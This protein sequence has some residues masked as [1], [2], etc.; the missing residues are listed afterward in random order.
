MKLMVL[1]GNSLV[2]RAFFGIK[3]LTTKDGRYTNAIY[4]FQNILLNLL[5]AHQPDAVAIA[6]DERAPTFRHNA[7]DGYKATRHGM[8]EELAQQMP[9]L[10]E[11]LTD[12]G[13]VQVSKAGWEADD[14]LGTLA[15]ACEAAGGTTL[16]ATGDRDSLQLVDDATTVLLATNK[17][18]IPMDPAAI[19]EKYGIE[20]PQLIDV[21]SLMGDSSDNIPGVPGIGE[22]TALALI[23]KFGSLQG[24]YDNIEDK[25]VKPGQRAKLTANRGKAD[26]SYMLGTIRRDAPIETD[27]SAYIRR[28]GDPAAAA[29]LLAALEMHKLVDRWG[30]E[31]GAA[32]AAAADAAP[33]QAVE[34]SPLPLLLE[35]RF[36]AAQ[37][38]TKTG[39]GSWYLVQGSEVYLPD[40]DRLAALLDGDAEI[41]AFDAKPLYR[42]ALAHG[43]V[44]K[45]LRFDGKLAA[46]LLNPSASGYEVKSLAAEYGVHAAFHCEDAP[47]AGVLAGLCDTLAAALDESGQRKLL[48]EMELPLARVLADMGQPA[49]RGKQV[50]TWLHRGVRSFDEMSN[51]SKPLRQQLA[52]AYTISVPTVARKQE[53]RLD[54]T[55]KYLW[56]LPDGNCIETVL[57]QYHHGSTVCISSQVGCRMGCAFCASTVAGKVRDLTAGEMLDQVLFTQLDSG[58]EISNIVLMG[59]GEPLD[60]RDNVLRFLRLVN[61]PDGLNIGMRHISLSTCGVVP[62]IDTL[63]EED[64]QLTLSVSLHA[65]DSET[66]SRIMPVNRAWDVEELFAACHRY[67]RRTGRRISF[68]YAMIDGVNDHDWQAD[69]IARRIAGMPGHVNLIPLNDVVESPFKPSRRIAAFQ[70]RLE[71]HGITATV[72]R[73][74]GGDIDASCGQLRRRAMEERKGEDPE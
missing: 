54:G 9:V 26:L 69:L 38:V 2:N 10:K 12:L 73:S 30:L 3:L 43:G 1:D 15:A 36:Y 47:D 40:T 20:P 53:S 44:G 17:E 32:P 60:N 45:A 65:P 63:A 23:S 48:D 72:R 8:P 37:N 7:Y 58:R 74:L 13:F 31:S 59:I 68:E 71:S 56:E 33:V 16:L 64:L 67:F 19:R 18:T 24:V 5:A 46:Y 70:K 66:R 52:Q 57:M 62:G 25:A 55:I 27:P 14:I 34:P 4:G 49:F 11:L 61:H 22:K 39:D 41:W 35:G 28:P 29:Q 50:F 21:K 51:L 6:W 42:L